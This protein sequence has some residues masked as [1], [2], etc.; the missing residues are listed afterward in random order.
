MDKFWI[1]SSSVGKGE[2]GVKKVAYKTSCNFKSP[3]DTLNH[4]TESKELKR[5]GKIVESMKYA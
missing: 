5:Y 1:S 4:N 3:L 2:L